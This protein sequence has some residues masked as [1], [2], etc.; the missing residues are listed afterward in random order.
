MSHLKVE[1]LDI[2]EAF[3]SNNPSISYFLNRESGEVIK[4]PD[5]FC[6]DETILG[7]DYFSDRKFIRIPRISDKE[8]LRIR[9]EYRTKIQNED[10]YDKLEDILMGRGALK[11]FVDILRVYPKYYTAWLDF[12]NEEIIKIIKDWIKDL[13]L[14]I[15][16]VN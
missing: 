13:D 12:K 7:I 8:G 6:P 9:E 3:E 16:L 14:D 5:D 11:K 2:I 4:V 10:L 1:R 15:D